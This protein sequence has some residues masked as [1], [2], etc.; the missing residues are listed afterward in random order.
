MFLFKSTKLAPYVAWQF[1]PVFVAVVMGILWGIVDASVR[2]MEPYYQLSRRMGI[3]AGGTLCSDY[4]MTWAF[5]IPL[6]SG[7]RGQWAVTLSSLVHVISFSFIPSLASGMLRITWPLPKQGEEAHAVVWIEK[8]VV[9]AALG[10]SALLVV[11]ATVL[12]VVLMRRTSGMISEPGGLAGLASLICDSE[13][14]LKIFRELPPCV[15]ERKINATLEG[16]MF[17]LQYGTVYRENRAPE[18]AYQIAVG[19]DER[20]YRIPIPPPF[21]L[22]RILA[23]P[24][25]D[26]KSVV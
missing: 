7:R 13:N 1:L 23:H 2:Q 3:P 19:V 21:R 24:L 11:L 12:M 22:Y 18:L 15:S 17:W 10:A 6:K 14:V 8:R 26:R 16:K 25:V 20:R 4:S 9:H 5:G